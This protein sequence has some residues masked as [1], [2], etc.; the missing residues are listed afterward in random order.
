MDAFQFL[1]KFLDCARRQAYKMGKDTDVIDEIDLSGL[2]QILSDVNMVGTM[3]PSWPLRASM[4]AINL[5]EYSDQDPT[6]YLVIALGDNVP[7]RMNPYGSKS[8]FKDLEAFSS[9]VEGGLKE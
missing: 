7:A 8:D 6:S 2:K 1:E 9:Y 5:M 4:E 3:Q